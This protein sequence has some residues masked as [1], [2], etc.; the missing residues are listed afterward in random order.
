MSTANGAPDEKFSIPAEWTFKTPEVAQAFD[1]H[2]REQLPWY[3]LATGIVAHV[4]RHYVPEGGTVVDIGASTG[5][6]GRALAKTLDVRRSRLIAIDNAE[7]MRS[8][9]AGPGEFVVS[10]ARAFDYAA[11][12]P[13]LIVAFLVLMFVPVTDRAAL[14]AKLKASVR[15]GGAVLIFDKLASLAGI[16]RP[17]TEADFEG[18]APIFRFGDFAGFLFEKP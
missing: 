3:D 6:V 18:F 9:Y 12:A 8:V 13:D 1:R 11:V 17:T 5:N 2:V 4:G 15:P 16:Q 7:D 10:D 14:L